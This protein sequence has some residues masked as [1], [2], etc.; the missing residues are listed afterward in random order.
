VDT[1][2][3]DFHETL[4]RMRQERLTAFQQWTRAHKIDV[5]A[6]STAGR[7]LDDL[8]RFFQQ[9]NNRLKHR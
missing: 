9:R 3:P 8:M 7:H 2:R 6:T 1:G 5:L 4:Q